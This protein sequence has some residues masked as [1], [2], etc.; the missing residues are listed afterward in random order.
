M[1]IMG[2]SCD[3]P[4]NHYPFLDASNQIS[5]FYAAGD[6]ELVSFLTVHLAGLLICTFL[7]ICLYRAEIKTAYMVQNKLIFND[8]T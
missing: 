8:I 6:W 3:R 2:D 4:L 1:A 7:F 5:C